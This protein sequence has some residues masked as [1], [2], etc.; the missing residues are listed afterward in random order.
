[1]KTNSGNF[2]DWVAATPLRF[3]IFIFVLSGPGGLLYHFIVARERL[4]SNLRDEV[5]LSTIAALCVA[6]FV[7]VSYKKVKP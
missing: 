5:L 2:W 6:I 7:Y 3:A 1:M 4:L